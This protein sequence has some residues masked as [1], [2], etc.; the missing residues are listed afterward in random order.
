MSNK[1]FS[2]AVA[3]IDQ[4]TRFLAQPTRQLVCINDVEMS[5]AKYALYREQLLAA[6]GRCFPEKSRF[7]L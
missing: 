1:H 7:E 3:S 6:F 4:I 5:D 2:L